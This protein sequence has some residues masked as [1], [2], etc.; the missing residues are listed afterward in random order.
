MAYKFSIT[1]P[2]KLVPKLLFAFT[3]SLSYRVT[4]GDYE[5]LIVSTTNS[6]LTIDTTQ[7]ESS[8][9]WRAKSYYKTSIPEILR[10]DHERIWMMLPWMQDEYVGMKV[11]WKSEEFTILIVA[12]GEQF[13]WQVHFGRLLYK[14]C[15]DFQ[16]GLLTRVKINDREMKAGE[17]FAAIL[18]ALTGDQAGLL[19]TLDAVEDRS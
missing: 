9:K 7:I 15:G 4:P 2:R 14:L 10:A 3:N 11:T 16:T 12:D 1:C 13:P 19:A 17:W 5:R 6:N 18:Y 8:F